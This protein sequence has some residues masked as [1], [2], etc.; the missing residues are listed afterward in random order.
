MSLVLYHHEFNNDELVSEV[1]RHALG[2]ECTQAINCAN[3]IINKGSYA[4][5]TFKVSE[6]KR[7]RATE[8][9][10]IEQGIPAKL[11]LKN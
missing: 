11:I 10:F 3:I 6:M 5:K 4:I 7:A 2:Y 1:I 8:E 9:L